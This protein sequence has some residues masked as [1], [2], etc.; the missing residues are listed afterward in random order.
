MILTTMIMD[1]LFKSFKIIRLDFLIMMM[2]V[3]IHSNTL[4]PRKPIII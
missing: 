1:C 3:T 4:V 2:I